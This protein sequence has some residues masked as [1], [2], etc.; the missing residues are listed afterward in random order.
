MRREIN[1]N[2]Y[3][4]AWSSSLGNRV[5]QCIIGND[6]NW[7]TLGIWTIYGQSTCYITDLSILS[8]FPSCK[9]LL[10]YFEPYFY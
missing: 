3:L 5:P 7:K 9:F 2:C 10:S 8:K 1:I 6:I 4:P